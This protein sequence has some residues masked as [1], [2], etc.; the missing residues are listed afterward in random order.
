M[1]IIV[2]FWLNWLYVSSF[3][4]LQMVKVIE[5]KCDLIN[6]S[7]G[8]ASN[9]CNSGQVYSDLSVHSVFFFS[10]VRCTRM[11][12]WNVF[13]V[14][15][16]GKAGFGCVVKA[17]LELWGVSCSYELCALCCC[18]V[19]HVSVWWMAY[20]R[21]GLRDHKYIKFEEV[22]LVV[23][24]LKAIRRIFFFTCLALFTI[25]YKSS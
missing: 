13:M 22:L 21:N 17:W 14:L 24:F 12:H 5:R 16:G 3:M 4:F 11:H 15:L 6:Y 18:Y 9:W 25:K 19:L 8:E 2:C 7:Y 23:K 20:F 1:F 10:A